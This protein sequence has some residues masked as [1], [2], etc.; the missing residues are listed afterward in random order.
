MKQKLNKLI[1]LV[2]QYT[3]K[4]VVLKENENDSQYQE[5]GQKITNALE[6]FLKNNGINAKLSFEIRNGRYRCQSQQFKGDSLGIFKYGMTD[7]IITN[8][9]GD[10]NDIK[11][12]M[13]WLPL[14]LN[15]NHYSD[16]S[17]RCDL[18]LT[19][20]GKNIF[21]DIDKDVVA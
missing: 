15:Y 14:K 10:L 12:N 9:G 8:W 21:Y 2:E 4:R 13:V 19:A 6:L 20:D 3:G 11:N 5:L 17:G 16:G 1:S 18:Y 7:C